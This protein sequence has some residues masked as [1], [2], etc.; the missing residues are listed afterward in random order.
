MGNDRC[1]IQEIRD[2][3]WYGDIS[4]VSI[5]TGGEG[6]ENTLSKLHCV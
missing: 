4:V 5:K 2:L 1:A 3:F 6:D